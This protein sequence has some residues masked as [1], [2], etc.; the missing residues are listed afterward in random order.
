MR[1]WGGGFK[2]KG[3]AVTAPVTAAG[4]EPSRRLPPAFDPATS[5]MLLAPE[6]TVLLLTTEES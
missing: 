6:G 2:G 3:L 5:R 1:G 4:I